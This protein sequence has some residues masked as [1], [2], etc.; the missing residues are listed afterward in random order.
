MEILLTDTY[1]ILEFC[2][3]KSKSLD[4]GVRLVMDLDK[5][6]IVTNL[7]RYKL[8]M[9]KTIILNDLSD[10]DPQ[11]VKQLSKYNSII[12]RYELPPDLAPYYT[13]EPYELIKMS[14]LEVHSIDVKATSKLSI[15]ELII[16]KFKDKYIIVCGKSLL[17]KVHKNS[18]TL[19][20]LIDYQ[21]KL[22]SNE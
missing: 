6:S 7:S 8:V 1:S 19:L 22:T 11:L 2:Y 14:N 18:P 3:L 21:L 12:S 13:Y 9:N 4:T 10:V 5:S 15:S 16:K 17:G 20:G